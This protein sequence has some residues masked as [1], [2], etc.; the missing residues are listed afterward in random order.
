[1]DI[2]ERDASYHRRLALI[3]TFVVAATVLFV[4]AGQ[5]YVHRVD[6][7]MV[8][9]KGAMELLPEL[10]IE[11][12]FVATEDSPE[13]RAIAK[14][15]SAKLTT[16]NATTE[17][18]V[19]TPQS[20]AELLNLQAH[21]ATSS[22]AARRS[23][24]VSYSE[25]YVILRMVD[26]VYPPDA[27]AANIEGSVTVELLIDEQGLVAQANVLN[28]VGPV[29]FREAALEA[30]R[31]FVFQPPIIDGEPSTMWIKFIYT[32]RLN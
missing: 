30:V 1:M 4:I 18:Q 5:N 6:P 15:P 3:S 17:F 20:D 26:P 10:A 29:S 24:P 27:R 2:Q 16:T 11:P 12:D 21:D 32:F 13:L 14:S 31:Q 22:D 23:R 8:G 28:L 25:S 7:V 19:A 9:W